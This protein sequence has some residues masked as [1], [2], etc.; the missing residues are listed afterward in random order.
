MLGNDSLTGKEEIRAIIKS[1]EHRPRTRQIKGIGNL[2]NSEIDKD[3]SINFVTSSELN[4][5]FKV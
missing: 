4:K 3:F 1:Y 2:P 5:Y